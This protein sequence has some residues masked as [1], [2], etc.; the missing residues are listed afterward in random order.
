VEVL[1]NPV[2]WALNAAQ[3]HLGSATERAA[4]YHPDISP[5][6]AFS[7]PPTV[8]HWRDL[9]GLVGPAGMA[10]VLGPTDRPPAGWTVVLELTGVQM[11]HGPSGPHAP[12]FRGPNPQAAGGPGG[13]DAV[14]ALGPDD[15]DEMLTLVDEAQPGPFLR[16]TVEFGGYLGVRRR[17][18]LVAMAG[19]RM[20]PPGHT[21]ISAVATAPD[22]RRQGLAG[23]L[24]D[25]V[26]EVILGRGET[27]FLH[28]DSRN[29]GAIRLY[30]SMGFTIRRTVDIQ[31]VEAP[32]TVE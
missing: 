11:V 20:S 3:V 17:G 8:D 5:F 29:T 12:T 10:A 24:V 21:E 31:V 28:A 22:H 2:W 7:G 15:V 30:E 27:P 13:D 18:R 16:R 6:A 26:V 32:G 23:R 19:Q 9:G 14:V 1:D 25:E 4:R